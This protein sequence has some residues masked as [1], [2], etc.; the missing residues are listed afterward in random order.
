MAWK[1]WAD[2][3][4]SAKR[5]KVFL[6]CE[7]GNVSKTQFLFTS[8]FLRPKP[9]GLAT[10]WF[11]SPFL[12]GASP[13]SLVNVGR[14]SVPVRVWLKWYYTGIFAAIWTSTVCFPICNHFPSMSSTSQPSPTG[15]HISRTPFLR[16]LYLP[17]CRKNNSNPAT[18]IP[19]KNESGII[20]YPNIIIHP[21]IVT[22]KTEVVPWR[23]RNQVYPSLFI[24]AK[25]IEN[26]KSKPFSLIWKSYSWKPSYMTFRW[27]HYC[28]IVVP[29]LDTRYSE[30]GETF[31]L[32]FVS[33]VET[34][35]ATLTAWCLRA[36]SRGGEESPET[37]KEITQSAR[38][39]RDVEVRERNIMKEIINRKRHV[40]IKSS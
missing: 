38:V 8:F 28:F 30:S 1:D 18:I 36:M 29:S 32:S 12:L 26:G 3:K 39:P 27:C 9:E 6:V 33:E 37:N 25:Q 23:P 20:C 24:F 35:T 5:A 16:L 17:I 2:L 31:D 4:T 11:S 15:Q 7:R 19:G 14:S 13:H 22:S 40:F 21:N 34:F 10:S